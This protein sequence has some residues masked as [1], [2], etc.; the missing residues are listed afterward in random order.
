MFNVGILTMW[1]MWLWQHNK[2]G[3]L[4]SYLFESLFSDHTYCRIVGGYRCQSL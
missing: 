3:D 1:L 2:E 4:A